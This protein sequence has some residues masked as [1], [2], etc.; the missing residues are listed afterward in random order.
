MQQKK[1]KPLTHHHP[2]ATY[3]LYKSLRNK[4]KES[5]VPPINC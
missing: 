1:K 3:F 4:K 5:K 2:E